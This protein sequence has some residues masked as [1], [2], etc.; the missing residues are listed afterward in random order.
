MSFRSNSGSVT[1]FSESYYRIGKYQTERLL[2]VFYILYA[3]KVKEFNKK[4][5]F[6]GVAVCPSFTLQVEF[7]SMGRTYC[8]IA[9]CQNHNQLMR[10]WK[11]EICQIHLKENVLCSCEPPVGYR[12][13]YAQT[14]SETE[15]KIWKENLNLEF[16]TWNKYNFVCSAHFIDRCPTKENPY[17][18]LDLSS[19]A[20]KAKK[21]QSDLSLAVT[22]PKKG[23]SDERIVAEDIITTK[24]EALVSGLR[25]R[26][27]Q[28][29][30]DLK[31]K[32]QM[33]KHL[34]NNAET[35]KFSAKNLLKGKG[36]FKFYTGITPEL[37]KI[38]FQNIAPYT[39]GMR[40]WRGPEMGKKVHKNLGH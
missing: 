1:I 3:Q 11:R 5:Q 35:S 40:Y 19:D 30:E 25:L 26:I 15:Q 39:E 18:V 37:F 2:P 36:T 4:D 22:E 12:V 9:N 29:E 21:R 24:E 27:K 6:S 8:V 34:Q 13:F 16:A 28:L 14:K 20:K 10:E 23:R 17:P 31:A 7:A 33:I 38:L 32:D